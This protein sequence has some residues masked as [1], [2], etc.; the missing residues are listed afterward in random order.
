MPSYRRL[1][2]SA[3]SAA[4]PSGNATLHQ[5]RS[6]IAFC[7]LKAYRES[8]EASLFEF[9]SAREWADLSIALKKVRLSSSLVIA[10]TP[11]SFS[12]GVHHAGDQEVLHVPVHPA[13]LHDH[14]DQAAGAV[15]A[16]R[17]AVFGCSSFGRSLMTWRACAQS[18]RTACTRLR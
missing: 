4:T 3:S 10:L 13:I 11:F 2:T 7:R 8:L 9:E 5:T 16:P 18:F 12:A 1:S 14:A 17:W 15:P 6:V